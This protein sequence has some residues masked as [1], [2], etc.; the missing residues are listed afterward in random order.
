M[1]L[2]FNIPECDDCGDQ[3]KPLFNISNQ[4]LCDDCARETNFDLDDF[5]FEFMPSKKMRVGKK[6]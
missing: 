1:T 5:D 4:T 2:N 6:K 3:E